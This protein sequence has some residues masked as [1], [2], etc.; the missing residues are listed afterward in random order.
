MTAE[1][2]TATRAAADFPVFKA[3]GSGVVCAAYGSYAVAANTEAGDIFK[4]CKLPAGAVVLGGMLYGAD[5]D[6]NATETIDLDVGWPANGGSG[7]YDAADSDGLGNFGVITGDAF[8]TG[9]V[10]NVTGVSYPLAGLLATGV[11]PAF[12]K[13]T[14]IQVLANAAAATFAAGTISVVVYYVVP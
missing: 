13:E 10:S 12:T 5:L 9:N 11:L 6:T 3:T 1:T 7:T 14:T 8:A 4:M 2:L